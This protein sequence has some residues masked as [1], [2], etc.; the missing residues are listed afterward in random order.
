MERVSM[1]MTRNEGMRPGVGPSA[2]NLGL[3]GLVAGPEKGASLHPKRYRILIVDDARAN[4]DLLAHSLS[5]LY[6]LSFATSGEAALK[7]AA[8]V[9]F[10]LVLL[11]IVMPTMNGYE[12]CRSCSCLRWGS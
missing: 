5:H 2:A 8:N 3:A 4:L 7:T 6:M 10:D 12:M 9:S 11:D 1:E